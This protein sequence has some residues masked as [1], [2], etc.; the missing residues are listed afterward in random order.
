MASKAGD[1]YELQAI[2][3]LLFG[4]VVAAIITFIKQWLAPP[5]PS[6]DKRE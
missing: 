4:V 2:D 6:N 1:S 5:K 3:Y